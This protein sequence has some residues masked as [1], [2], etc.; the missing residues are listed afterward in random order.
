MDVIVDGKIVLHGTVGNLY[1]EEGFTARDVI[2]ALATLGRSNDVTVS[3]NSGGGIAWEGVAIFNALSAHSGKVTIEVEGIAASAASVIAMAG[4]EVV[5]RTGSLMMIHDPA[6]FTF[7][8]ADDHQK[9]IEMLD[10]MGE[11]TASIYAEKTGS[12]I[13][14]MRDLMKAE[15]WMTAAEAVDMKFADSTDQT[16]AAEATAFNYC[17]YG[18]A[19][20][21][22]TALATARQ[23]TRTKPKDDTMTKTPTATA[24]APAAPVT[25]A[26]PAAAPV[27]SAT[28]ERAAER[29][30]IAA[31]MKSPEAK[32]REQLAEHLVELE[33]SAEAAIA[34]LSKAPKVASQQSVPA[35]AT[36]SGLE[37]ASPA[38]EMKKADPALNAADIYAARRTQK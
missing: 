3:I 22:L 9:S 12:K 18:Q 20:E 4:D 19:P 30:R 32:G 14:A 35:T 16:A 27:A 7:G 36:L 25:Q 11:Q 13:S 5:M 6:L 33:M 29:A 21:R 15:T 26:A 23:W 31:I 28:D 24:A 2:E 38:P 17:M 1:W 37:L 8:N 34:L 10:K